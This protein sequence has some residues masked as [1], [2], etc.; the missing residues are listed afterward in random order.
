[1]VTCQ[2]QATQAG[3]R[4]IWVHVKEAQDLPARQRQR[5]VPFAIGFEGGRRAVV[6]VTVDLHDQPPVAPDE[7]DLDSLDAAVDF[8][9]WQAVVVAQLEEAFLELAARRDRCGV[10]GQHRL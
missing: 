8:R 9:P 7:V 1:M 5:D 6:G 3:R 4:V 2:A 10:E